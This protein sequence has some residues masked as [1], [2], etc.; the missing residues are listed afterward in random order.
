MTV[1]SE[2]VSWAWRLPLGCWRRKENKYMRTASTIYLLSGLK[3][4]RARREQGQRSSWAPGQ[5]YSPS[6][7][8]PSQALLWA[9][10]V[11]WPPKC[12]FSPGTPCAP[13]PQGIPQFQDNVR[14]IS[15]VKPP[16]T[17]FLLLIQGRAWQ[18]RE[19]CTDLHSFPLVY[20]HCLPA[21]SPPT[22]ML[23]PEEQP[24]CFFHLFLQVT[25][26]NKSTK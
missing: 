7:Q 22:R 25:S 6:L 19:S 4:P 1:G 11:A 21:I 16:I 18:S 2:D 10:Q 9:C 13:S 14:T 17:F 12:C 20:G 23:V 26:I 24:L 15:W 8:L 5:W 3:K